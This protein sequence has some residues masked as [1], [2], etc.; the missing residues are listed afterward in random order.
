MQPK[1]AR[2]V[3]LA[4]TH[5]RGMLIVNQAGNAGTFVLAMPDDTSPVA[6][7]LRQLCDDV[8]IK[9]AKIGSTSIDWGDT[10]SRV[11]GALGAPL[12]EKEG[13]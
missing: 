1:P 6:E 3:A 7:Q 9:A 2:T 10:V 11:L 12:P 5:D 4:I 13:Q 8:S